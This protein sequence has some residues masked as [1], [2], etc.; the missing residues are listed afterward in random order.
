MSNGNVCVYNIDD[1]FQNHLYKSY[2]IIIANTA[3]FIENLELLQINILL[4][5]FDQQVGQL[6]MV[7]TIGV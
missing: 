3:L 7:T 5:W 1:L 6:I 4:D 2:L